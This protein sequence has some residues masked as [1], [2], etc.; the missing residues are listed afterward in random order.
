MALFMLSSVCWYIRALREIIGEIDHR[1][2]CQV[3]YG[4]SLEIIQILL[5]NVECVHF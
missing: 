1:Y 4:N 3:L 2:F 5:M